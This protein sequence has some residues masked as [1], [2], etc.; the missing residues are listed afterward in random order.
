MSKCPQI[1]RPS[2]VNLVRAF[3]LRVSK[4]SIFKI[5]VFNAATRSGC[6]LIIFWESD[7]YRLAQIVELTPITEQNSACNNPWDQ[8]SVK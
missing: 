7:D 6:Y 2:L 3:F 1:S 5:P 8:Y 4:L